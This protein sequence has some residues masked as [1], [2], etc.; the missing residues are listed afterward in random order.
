MIKTFLLVLSAASI[1]ICQSYKVT[2]IASPKVLPGETV[3]ISGNQ[4]KLGNWRP[5]L[6]KL[7]KN[8]D[9]NWE[10]TI[11]FNLG[12]LI[13]FKFTRG[14]WSNEAVNEKGEIP[15]NHILRVQN[16]TTIFIVIEN[17]KDNFKKEIKSTAKGNIKTHAGL[18]GK[19]IKP[20]DVKVWLP[21]SYEE[22][23][24][25]R[26]PVLYMHDGQNVFDVLTSSF[27][28][29]WQ[30]DETTD[31]LISINEIEEI[32]VVAV[33]NTPDRT[34]EYTSEIGSR[35]YMAFITEKLKP[36]I[37]SVYRTKPGN[38]NNAVMG[39]SAGGLISFLLAWN[40]P[41]IFGKAA[42]LSPAFKIENIDYVTPVKNHPGKKD[43]KI[44][45]DNGGIGLEE[46][47]QP[48][49]DEMAA[50]LKEKGYEEGGDLMY[51]VDVKAEHNEKAW[52][53]RAALPL[54][55]LFGK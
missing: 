28:N 2:F 39:S 48:G 19:G 10:R 12:T 11:A 30:I 51:I 25:K 7:E 47:L 18:K 54:K 42:C 29:E 17:W 26:Y 52:A 16:D 1:I 4:H 35:L 15:S 45:I 53:N 27:G 37:D 5:D 23:N 8:D 50:A 43:I 24:D 34:K 44:Y 21:P 32:I 55:F 36:M 20:R 3:F 38:I 49:I 33:D 6:V 46:R 40:Y 14:L 22:N 41:E 9:G 13:E 31:S